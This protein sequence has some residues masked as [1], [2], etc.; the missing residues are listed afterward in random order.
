MPCP[1][2]EP[3]QVVQGKTGQN[4][5]HAARQSC[6]KPWPCSPA[7]HQPCQP[8]S[9]T[10]PELDPGE[11]ACPRHST[12]PPV[13][14]ALP[15]F[16]QLSA[17]LCL[18]PPHL[19]PGAELGSVQGPA[20]AAA[21]R[22]GALAERLWLSPHPHS[23]SSAAASSAEWQPCPHSTHTT[24]PVPWVPPLSPGWGSLG[25]RRGAGGGQ[26]EGAA[27]TV[28][29]VT[30]TARLATEG[31]WPPP[32]SCLSAGGGRHRSNPPGPAWVPAPRPGSGA[33]AS[34]RRGQTALE[35][36]QGCCCC[37]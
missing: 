23:L 17:G 37:C 26:L 9:H 7:S 1:H 10:H 19:G 20:P 35:P 29:V 12:A 8:G 5:A 18:P 4:W 33:A 24:H 15:G 22:G 34:T 32:S 11:D 36:P 6:C 16:N 3:H 25:S 13:G 2:P 21:N 31:N 28:R 30:A 14:W 27:A